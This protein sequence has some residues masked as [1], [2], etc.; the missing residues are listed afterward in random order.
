MRDLAEGTITA[1]KCSHCGVE[2][3]TEE[4]C[5]EKIFNE[6][7]E[8]AEKQK[9]RDNLVRYTQQFNTTNFENASQVSSH[10]ITTSNADN[11]S[12]IKGNSSVTATF[13]K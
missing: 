2:G 11:S 7:K 9:E 8:R 4:Q 12:N 3:H 10:E 5:V 1:P 6:E 13:R